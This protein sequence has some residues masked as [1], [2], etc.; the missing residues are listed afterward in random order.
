MPL[1]EIVRDCWHV[2]AQLVGGQAVLATVVAV[3]LSLRL[4]WALFG[5]LR[6]MAGEHSPGSQLSFGGKEWQRLRK[7]K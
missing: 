2:V 4:S 7:G 6:D 5:V 1:L 3:A